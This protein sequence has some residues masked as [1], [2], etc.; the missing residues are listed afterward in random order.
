MN[1]FL[2]SPS[3]GR[4]EIGLYFG[5]RGRRADLLG[6]CQDPK[7]GRLAVLKGSERHLRP[8]QAESQKAG[9]QWIVG[10]SRC[11]RL[12]PVVETGQAWEDDGSPGKGGVTSVSQGWRVDGAVAIAVG[13]L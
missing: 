7:P 10:D 2:L 11:H 9:C 5:Y 4:V 8:E 12:E 6:C 1:K 13:G 3:I